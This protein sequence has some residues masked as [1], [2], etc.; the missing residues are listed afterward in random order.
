MLGIIV[1]FV[2][3]LL[4][5]ILLGITAYKCTNAIERPV[6]TNKLEQYIGTRSLWFSL[7]FFV[8]FTSVPTLLYKVRLAVKCN[9]DYVE[10]VEQLIKLDKQLTFKDN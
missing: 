6:T 4:S 8:P 10:Y 1:N 5:S 7:Y 2:A 9:F 3:E